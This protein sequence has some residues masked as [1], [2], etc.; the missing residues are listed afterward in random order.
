MR[1]VAVLLLTVIASSAV[2]QHTDTDWSR[3]SAALAF[4]YA[5]GKAATLAQYRITT[6]PTTKQAADAA[7]DE[8]DRR[9]SEARNAFLRVQKLG[10]P[11]WSAAATVRV[12]DMFACQAMV[13]R[14]IPVPA[15]L[16][17]TLPPRALVEYRAVMF[18]LAEPLLREAN[19]SWEGAMADH[20]SAY[21]TAQ[22]RQRLQDGAVPGC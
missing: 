18:G 2:A 12:G 5:E 8:L 3:F 15:K 20:A 13:I 16:A 17:A 21:W 22:A 9:A 11:F 19:D 6:S 7:L 4:S 14:A 1:A 10:S